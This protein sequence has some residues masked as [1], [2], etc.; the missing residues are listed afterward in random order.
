VRVDVSNPH[1]E[2]L[3]GELRF[4]AA[5]PAEVDVEMAVVEP[6]T[7]ASRRSLTQRLIMLGLSTNVRGR[8]SRQTSIIMIF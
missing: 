2:V 7:A 4:V 1:G 5:M 8:F 6:T 3:T